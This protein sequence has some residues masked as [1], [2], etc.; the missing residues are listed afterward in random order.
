MPDFG[1]SRDHK[2]HFGDFLWNEI[3]TKKESQENH[4]IDYVI[5]DPG[6]AL[7]LLGIHNNQSLKSDLNLSPVG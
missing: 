6:N 4:Q 5:D 7:L 3:R 1:V 2:F